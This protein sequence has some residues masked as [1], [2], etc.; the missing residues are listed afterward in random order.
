MLQAHDATTNTTTTSRATL[1]IMGFPFLLRRNYIARNRH[2]TS[3]TVLYCKLLIIDKN[4]IIYNDNNAY[5]NRHVGFEGQLAT[6]IKI[7][8]ALQRG[9]K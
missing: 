7:A 1:P 3:T 6:T 8:K 5:A 2:I 9:K 4:S